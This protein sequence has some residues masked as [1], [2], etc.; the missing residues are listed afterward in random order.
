MLKNIDVALQIGAVIREVGVNEREGRQV[1]VVVATRQ[2]ETTVEDLWDA[3]TSEARIPRWFLPVSGDLKPG[4][5]FKLEGNA[6]GDILECEPPRRLRLSWEAGGQTSWVTVDLSSAEGG[7]ALLRLEHEAPVPDEMWKQFG[8]GAVGIG[9]DLALLGLERHLATGESADRAAAAAW[10]AS[11]EGRSFIGK[12]SE[13]WKQAS[14]A[15]GTGETEAAQAA[16]RTTAFYT[17]GG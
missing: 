13:E 6:S 10:P 5:R 12:C 3:I 9:W 1:R 4:G 7:A 8:P 16:E 11:A 14:V 15:A 2:Y 17:G